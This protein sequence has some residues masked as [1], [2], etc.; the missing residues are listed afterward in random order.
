MSNRLTKTLFHVKSNFYFVVVSCHSPEK[1]YTSLSMRTSDPNKLKNID[2]TFVSGCC[3]VEDQCNMN[4]Q[5][6]LYEP[7]TYRRKMLSWYLPLSRR[8]IY[9]KALI[10][11]GSEALGWSRRETNSAISNQAIHA[12][13]SVIS[14]LS[15][16][17]HTWSA[18]SSPS[19]ITLAAECDQEPRHPC[20]PRHI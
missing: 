16:A 12:T 10:C 6:V 18:G 9:R 7:I 5:R 14:P 19:C 17:S 4:L 15:Q 2:E 3:R 20:N 13:T 1:G 11:D 8:N